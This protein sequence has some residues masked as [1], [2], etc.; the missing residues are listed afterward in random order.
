MNRVN[1]NITLCYSIILLTS[2]MSLSLAIFIIEFTV[3]YLGIDELFP[4]KNVNKSIDPLE[5]KMMVQSIWTDRC[6]GKSVRRR[7]QLFHNQ[8]FKNLNYI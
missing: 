8:R 3:D 7:H 2:G 5:Q 4:E 1:I 6:I